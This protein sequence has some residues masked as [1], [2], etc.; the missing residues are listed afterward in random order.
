[1]DFMRK[2]ERKFGKYGIPNLTMIVISCYV[3]G[4]FIQM[5][6]P[7]IIDL[8]SLNVN[9][10]LRGQIWRLVT[11]VLSP[12]GSSNLFFFILSI[13]FFYYPIG[14]SLEKTIGDF[15]YT[16]YMLNGVLL[17]IIGAFIAHFLSSGAVDIYAS[18]IFTTYYI[19]LSVFLA[20]AVLFPDMQLLLW[21]VIPIKMKWMAIV[22]LVIMGYQVLQ[23]VR[24]G[25]IGWYFS[26]PILASLLNFGIF[27]LTGKDLSRYRPKEMQRRREFHKAMRPEGH[28]RPGG[29]GTITKHKCAICGRTEKDSPDLEFRF[30]SRCKG[31]YEYCQDHLFTHSHVQ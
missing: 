20:F 30:C 21:F 25:S 18:Y 3:I 6:R 14:K 5:L 22:Y 4:Y 23:Y 24:Y 28:M 16:C 8:L 27:Y 17:T 31:N 7:D 1:M 19:S 10:I 15:R 12:P 9:M 26:I 2:L 11:W 29:N 13:V